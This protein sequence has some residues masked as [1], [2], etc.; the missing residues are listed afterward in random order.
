MCVSCMCERA[1][2]GAYVEVRQQ[3]LEVG[4]LFLPCGI[5]LR[6]PGFVASAFTSE[7]SC[8]PYVSGKGSERLRAW[9]CPETDSR[10]HGTPAFPVCTEEPT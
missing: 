5:E 2:H 8:Q 7:P 6:P 1:Y 9:V 4:S 10:A 3:V